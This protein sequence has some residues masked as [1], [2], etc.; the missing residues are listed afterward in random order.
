MKYH[1]PYKQQLIKTPV[2]LKPLENEPV[3]KESSE[4][5][6]PLF[7]WSHH[8]ETTQKNATW[9]SWHNVDYLRLGLRYPLKLYHTQNTTKTQHSIIKYITLK[10]DKIITL[11]TK[12]AFNCNCILYIH[13]LSNDIY[14]N[15]N[16]M[17]WLFLQ[18]KQK[19]QL[20]TP[21]FFP[22]K[23]LSPD[24]YFYSYLHY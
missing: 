24:T 17:K 15:P 12:S 11:P 16:Q 9:T 5:V 2:A 4:Q 22:F 23:W 19:C 18:G 7:L 14:S 6:H 3:S 1:L 8:S 20:V 21:I 13:K 10:E